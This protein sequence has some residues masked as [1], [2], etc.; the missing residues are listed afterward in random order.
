MK[1]LATKVKN[2]WLWTVLITYP[3]VVLALCGCI[4]WMYIAFFCSPAYPL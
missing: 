3:I 4:A 1:N 2:V